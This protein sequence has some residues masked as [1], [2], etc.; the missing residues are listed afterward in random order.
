MPLYYLN[1]NAPVDS[2]GIALHNPFVHCWQFYL[3]AQC[4]FTG[5]SLRQNG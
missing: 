1:Q 3:E 2:G 5:H 4:Q